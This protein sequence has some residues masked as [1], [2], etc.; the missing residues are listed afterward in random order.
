MTFSKS[1]PLA[2]NASRYF[3]NNLELYE[4]TL[5]IHR[6]SRAAADGN[7]QEV[8]PGIFETNM[9]AIQLGKPARIQSV[10]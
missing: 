5:E 2:A 4:T 10:M 7:F 9:L 8:L 6:I 3:F 1:R